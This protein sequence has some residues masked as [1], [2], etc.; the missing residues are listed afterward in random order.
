MGSIERFN[1]DPSSKAGD[2]IN[3]FEGTKKLIK[4][5]ERSGDRGRL[6]WLYDKYLDLTL[7]Y[8]RNRGNT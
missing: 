2:V 1:N 5:A 6:K 4:K 8:F 7:Y 3:I